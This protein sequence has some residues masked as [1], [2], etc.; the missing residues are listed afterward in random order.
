M[1]CNNV[2]LTSLSGTAKL[3]V[4]F[5]YDSDD[6]R[7][8]R[9]ADDGSMTELTSQYFRELKSISFDTDHF[10]VFVAVP[11]YAVTSS[12]DGPSAG[13]V[14]GITLLIALLAAGVVGYAMHRRL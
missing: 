9:I 6:N 5:L 4:P 10:S 8:Y 2:A 12:D 14:V 3:T 1:T 7:V 13:M 11:A